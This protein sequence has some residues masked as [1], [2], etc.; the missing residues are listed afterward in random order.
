MIKYIIKFSALFLIIFL[1]SNSS[2]SQNVEQLKKEAKFTDNPELWYELG[3]IY[4]K[5]ELEKVNLKKAAHY[6]EKAAI[7]GHVEASFQLANL[8]VA[9]NE[10]GSAI[11]LYTIAADGGSIESA[12]LLGKFYKEGS[13]VTKD[14]N[15]SIH[16]F[17]ISWNAGYKDS[18]DQLDALDTKNYNKKE[19]DILYQKY[20]AH[21]GS[22]KSE[23]DLGIA[24]KNGTDVKQ[25]LEKSFNLFSNS[26]ADNYGLA[27][28]ELGLF[29]KN[30]L[31][32][33]KDTQKAVEF[34]VKASNNGI[35]EAA[36]E[37]EKMDVKT[38]IKDNDIEF[39]KYQAITNN[40]AVAQYELYKYYEAPVA[41]TQDMIKAVEFCQRS[42]LQDYTPAMLA[43]SDLYLK[44]DSL[45]KRNDASAFK[46]RRQAAFVGSDSAEYLLG[47]MYKQGIGV[48][49]SDEKAVR[50]YLKAANH[51]IQSAA[52]TLKTLNIDQYLNKSDLEYATFSANQGDI[53]AQMMLGRYY[54]KNDKAPAI[55]WLQKASLQNNAEAEL[56]LGD[57]Y[58]EGKCQTVANPSTAEMH[59]KKAIA[60]G[61]QDAYLKMADLYTKDNVAGGVDGTSST[62]EAM[63]YANTYMTQASYVNSENTNADPKA[64]LLMGDILNGQGKTVDAIKQYDLYIKSFDEVDGNH[65]EFITVM[66]KQA[67]AYAEIG[68]VNSA[69]LQIEIA[70]AKADDFSM[71]KDFKDNY[72]AIK[73]ELFYTQGKL[74]FQQGDKYKACGVF[75]KVKALGIKLDS[76]YENLCSN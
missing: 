22:A 10:Y 44:G 27:Q 31:L 73:G 20:L 66:N 19:S 40:N 56:L 68:E 48:P 74:L 5:G 28:Y 46:W 71:L 1:F 54:F 11:K 9:K 50:W 38:F 17:L 52:D 76:K 21:N 39:I 65:Q 64:F 60:L 29:Y 32:G 55:V 8:K 6:Y 12:Y 13:Q 45:I 35:Q 43:L 37:L 14:V 33:R 62:N 41:G 47:N 2:F 69:L 61:S 36:K 70:L 34:F 30:G 7:K 3:L 24:Y 16:Y 63:A 42:A 72:S 18:K 57:I 67:V 25:D 23:Y 49:K 51:G 58:K 53:E 59:Y 4:Q 26:A 15:L 75:Q